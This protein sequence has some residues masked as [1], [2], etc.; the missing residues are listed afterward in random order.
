V[1]HQAYVLTALK[2]YFDLADGM[3]DVNVFVDVKFLKK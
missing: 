2:A 3:G 1:L